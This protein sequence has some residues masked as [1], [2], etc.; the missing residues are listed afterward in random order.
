MLE[1][2]EVTPSGWLKEQLKIQASGLSG[3]LYD[4]WDSVGSYNGWLGGTG[5]NWE[6]APYFLDGIL[7]LAYYLKDKKL[8]EIAQKYIDCILDS[9]DE[10]GNFGPQDTKDDWWSR[11][12]ALKVFVQYYEITKEERVLDFMHRYYHF[13]Q[14]KLPENPREGIKRV[15]LKG[16]EF[17]LKGFI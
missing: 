2:T 12:V 7:P 14:K 6:R 4:V 13:Q 17:T 15:F 5:D 3:I 11:M 10:E 8:W 9:Q 16:T 1:L